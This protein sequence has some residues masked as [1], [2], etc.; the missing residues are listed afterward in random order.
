MKKQNV[1]IGMLLMGLIVAQN[2]ELAAWMFA[3][4]LG[5]GGLMVVLYG[6]KED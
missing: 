6:M 3:M 5:V 2:G 1:G 4:I